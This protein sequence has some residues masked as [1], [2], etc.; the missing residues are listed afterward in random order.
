MLLAYLARYPTA[1]ESS[2][3]G[4]QRVYRD[5]ALGHG[6]G[7]VVAIEALGDGD[8]QIWRWPPGVVVRLT[9]RAASLN[10]GHPVASSTGQVQA[11]DDYVATVRWAHGDEFSHANNLLEL[12]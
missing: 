4:S 2:V 11:S 9:P 8:C 3:A 5:P 7:A 12:A 10:R 1:L 6:P